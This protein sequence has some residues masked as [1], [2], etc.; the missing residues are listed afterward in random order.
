MGE[1]RLK[2]L[3]IQPDYPRQYVFF[4][5]VYE[6][7]HGLLFGAI[8]RDLAETRLFDRRFD[9]DENLARL[10]RDYQPDIVG[11]TTHTAGEIFNV[12]RLLGIVKR[13]S[14]R[15]VTMVGGQHSSLLPEDLFDPTVDL[16][17][18]GPGEE[19]F[20]EVVELLASKGVDPTATDD[21]RNSPLH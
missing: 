14:P 4:F 15:A 17:C 13:E 10:A 12:K 8:I 2:F 9:T 20:R 16:V 7:L 5:P 1:Q 21:N 6:P 19:T 3:F 11:V 18:I